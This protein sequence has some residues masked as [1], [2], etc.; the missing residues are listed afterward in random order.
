MQ[1]KS[2]ELAEK[3]NGLEYGDRIAENH[4]EFAKTNNLV[5]VTGYSD[6]NV[7]F[8]GAIY[9]EVPAYNGTE[10]ALD[11]NGV[12]EECEEAC[13][14]C[15]QEN[16][17]AVASQKIKAEWNANG[18]SWYMTAEGINVAYFDV[19]ED[20]EKFCR[21]LVFDKSELK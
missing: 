3:L 1:S 13:D 8:E 15:D 9:E 11:A 14:H 19:L 7:E 18:Y 6:D 17:I 5:I 4:L 2:H 10:I 20:K 21:G 12:I 16:K